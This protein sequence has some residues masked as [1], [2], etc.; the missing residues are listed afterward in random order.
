MLCY[1]HF[2]NHKRKYDNNQ[3]NGKCKSG[4]IR[5]TNGSHKVLEEAFMTVTVYL[6]SMCLGAQRTILVVS[7]GIKVPS[8]KIRILT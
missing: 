7:S 3:T 5:K 1:R 6:N 8:S 2:Y 4:S